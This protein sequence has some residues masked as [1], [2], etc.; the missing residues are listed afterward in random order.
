MTSSVCW[1]T[2]LLGVL[3]RFPEISVSVSELGADLKWHFEFLLPVLYCC[4]VLSPETNTIWDLSDSRDLAEL[5][6]SAPLIKNI[7]PVLM[8]ML[9]VLL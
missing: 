9:D 6:H 2:L 8:V 1:F 5:T 4:T 3:I 7:N